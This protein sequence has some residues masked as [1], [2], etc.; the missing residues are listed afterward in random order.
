[1]LN[2]VGKGSLTINKTQTVTNK[3]TM[4]PL[5]LNKQLEIYCYHVNVRCPHRLMCEHVVPDLQHCYG[6]L[7]EPL[8]KQGLKVNAQPCSQSLIS[9]P[10]RPRSTELLLH[11]PS[12][13]N[14]ALPSPKEGLEP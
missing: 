10:D 7:L 2:I 3:I 6:R 9:L 13:M 4:C 11:S 12:T 8:G 14:C 5:V 1:M